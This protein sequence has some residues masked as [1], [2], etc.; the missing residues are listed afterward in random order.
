[1]LVIWT[2]CMAVAIFA[3]FLGIGG[4]CSGLSGSALSECQASAWSRGG[5][6]LLL[7]GFLWLI[8]AA[9]LMLARYLMRPRSP[10]GEQL[11]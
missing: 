7:L 1:L 5:I 4:D 10:H 3:A 6:G 9:P 8:F 11:A 2:I